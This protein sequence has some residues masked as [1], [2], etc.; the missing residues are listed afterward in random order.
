MKQ[1]DYP[2]TAIDRSSLKAELMKQQEIIEEFWR[3]EFSVGQFSGIGGVRLQYAVR[4]E[5]EGHTALVVVSGRTEF[6][7]KYAE[8]FYDLRDAGL[9]FYIYDH[10]GQGSSQRLLADPRKGHVETYAD[11][12]GDLQIFIDTVVQAGR[13]RNIVLLSH[14]MGGTISLLYALRYQNVLSGLILA[15][16]MFSINTRP[17]PG[18]IADFLCRAAILIGRERDYALGAGPWIR[19]LLFSGNRLTGSRA[20]FERNRRFVAE[21]PAL[22]LGGPTYGWLA[23]SF[24]VTADLR[25]KKINL[26]LPVLL[27]QGEA[28]RVVGLSEPIEICGRFNDCRRI[29]FPGGRHELFMEEDCFRTPALEE[30]RSFI[31]AISR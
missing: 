16:P 2:P 17:F 25:K 7:E 5:N 20:R 13:P 26:T 31:A 10:R 21:N 23:Q 1:I 15:S 27:L 29:S 22:S 4:Q 28:D 19:E 14:S 8:F 12:V 30:V 24:S 9:S 6:M 18:I 11:Y 3:R